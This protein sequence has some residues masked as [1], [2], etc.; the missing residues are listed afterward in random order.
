MS[1]VDSALNAAS[2]VFTM[3]LVRTARPHLPDRQLVRLGRLFTLV[4]MI[5]ATA[6]TPFIAGQFETLF[7][8]FQATLSYIV[9]PIVAVYLAG[10]FSR[11]ASSGAAFWALSIGLGV[12]LSLFVLREVTGLWA[13]AGLPVIHFT[14]MALMLFALAVALLAAGSWRDRA[15][16]D[17]KRHALTFRASDLAVA[18]RAAPFRWLA[19]DRVLS[20]ALLTAMGGLIVAFW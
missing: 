3:D 14:Y 8:Y 13:M 11:L 9:P 16:P 4:L 10:L 15:E 20:V 18:S 17:P 1:S 19:D 2:S 5:A 6:Y 7:D 12:G